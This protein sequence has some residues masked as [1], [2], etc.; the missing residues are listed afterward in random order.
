ML[1]QETWSFSGSVKLDPENPAFTKGKIT[2]A[3]TSLHVLNPM[4]TAEPSVEPFVL[5]SARSQCR[6]GGSRSVGVL[7]KRKSMPSEPALASLATLLPKLWPSTPTA[8]MCLQLMDDLT[9]SS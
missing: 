3:A 2:V 9:L 5:Q 8:M 4:M 1:S 6:F 7:T